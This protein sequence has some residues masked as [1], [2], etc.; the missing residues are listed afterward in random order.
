LTD[1]AM[2]DR[3][4]SAALISALTTEHFV[5]QTAASST[6]T[7][8]GV[9]SSL[10]VFAV[11]SSLVAMGFAAQ[12]PAVFLPLVAAV[13]P[14]VF[15]MGL[16][17]V[18]RL[19]DLILENQQYLAGI[20]RIRGRYRSLGS[21]AARYFAPEYGR[22]PEAAVVPS[23]RHGPLIATLGTTATMVAF[24]NSVIGGAG[25]AL[26]LAAVFGHNRL[27]AVGGGIGAAA[28]L[29]AVFVAYQQWRMRGIQESANSLAVNG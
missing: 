12:L 11:S 20:A 27:L 25:V 26:A 2:N 14:A 29:S 13:L 18:V 7:E 24:I 22:W 19:V 9:R 1:E 17:T 6:I 28:V 21:E 8:A 15:L 23:L 3:Q 4:P 10:Y 5:L 16:M